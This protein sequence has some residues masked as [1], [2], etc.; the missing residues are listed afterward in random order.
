MNPIN[1]FK[2]LVGESQ[3]TPQH[4]IRMFDSIVSQT[5]T[6]PFWLFYTPVALLRVDYQ[7]IFHQ[8]F[9]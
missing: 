6:Q 4:F 1:W 7:P 5:I 8:A 3:T 9:K 2:V